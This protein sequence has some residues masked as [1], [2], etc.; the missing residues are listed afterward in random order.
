MKRKQRKIEEKETRSVVGAEIKKK[1]K[2]EEK[3]KVKKKK[4][5]ANWKRSETANRFGIFQPNPDSADYRL[6]C[7]ILVFSFFNL[8]IMKW[9]SDRVSEWVLVSCW[10]RYTK[11]PYL[12]WGLRGR[13]RKRNRIKNTKRERLFSTKH[14]KLREVLVARSDW[15]RAKISAP[16]WCRSLIS[17]WISPRASKTKGVRRN[18]FALPFIWYVR[19]TIQL[20]ACNWKMKKKKNRKRKIDKKEARI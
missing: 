20:D 17:E 1:K 4:K 9:V 8:N 12:K 13:L 18:T 19:K 16:P 15:P 14:C 11:K 2:I 10:P 5:K 6:F 7:F 3:R